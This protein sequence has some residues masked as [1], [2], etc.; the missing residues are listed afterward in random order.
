MRSNHIYEVVTRQKHPEI[1]YL[2]VEHSYTIKDVATPLKAHLDIMLI[3]VAKRA[4]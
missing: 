4:I 1:D 3:I 2:Q